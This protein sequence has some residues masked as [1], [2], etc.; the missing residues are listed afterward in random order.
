MKSSPGIC[1]FS[2]LGSTNGEVFRYTP[3]T[4]ADPDRVQIVR[5]AVLQ[6]MR[7]MLDGTLVSDPLCV[8]VK[9]E[10]HTRRKL[11]QGRLRLI[12]AVSLVDTLID[13]VLLGW[14]QRNALQNIGATP[15]LTGW[16]PMGGGWKYLYKRFV[17]KPTMCLDKSSWDWTVQPYLVEMWLEFVLG[18]AVEHPQWWRTL[19][20]GRFKCLFD[21]ARFEFKDKTVAT[22]NSPGIMKSGCLLTLLLNSVG[23]SLLH[24]LA[25][26][27][28]GLNPLFNQPVCVGDD[29]VQETVEPLEEYV[30]QIENLGAKVKGFKVRNWVEFCGFA[31][32]NGTCVPA[33]WQKHLFKLKYANLEDCLESYQMIYANE[34]EMF[35]FLNRVAVEV[36]PVLALHPY[37]ARAVMNGGSLRC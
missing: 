35:E 23:Q 20:T 28:L 17:G 24:Y 3:E 21:E 31:F 30:Q 11:E 27:R 36:S 13:R 10:P 29:T 15:C 4:G 34:P 2:V 19:V 5:E 16:S 22:Q 6:R 26:G 7:M 18:I 32:A 14:M 12:S 1:Q 8:F 9:P 25:M 37:Q 33:Y